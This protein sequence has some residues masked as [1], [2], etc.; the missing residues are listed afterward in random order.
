MRNAKK[1]WMLVTAIVM[2]IVL[3]LLLV[4]CDGECLIK[5]KVE[6]GMH[7]GFVQSKD[8]GSID[9]DN[10]S[11][12]TK[13][14]VGETYYMVIDFSITTVRGSIKTNEI[15]FKIRIE[16]VDKLQGWIEDANTA[17]IDATD[18]TVHDGEGNNSKEAMVTFSVPRKAKKTVEKRVIIKLEPMTKGDTPIKGVFE[19]ENVEI[20]GD[21]RDGFTKNISSTEVQIETPQ[22]SVDKTTGVARWYHVEHAD[23]Y[24]L[25]VDGVVTEHKKE[26]DNIKAGTELNWALSELGYTNGESIQI[27]AYSNNKNYTQ[28]N[29]SNA[30]SVKL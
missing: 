20:L 12:L 29:P 6:I 25:V 15:T 26:V 18:M 28:S 4:A 11:I 3:A 27:V 13:F 7:Y 16:N 9:Y 2:M 10:T 24:K 19:G 5:Q 17:N 21:G 22:L 14:N 8:D 30:D 1:Y 23:Y